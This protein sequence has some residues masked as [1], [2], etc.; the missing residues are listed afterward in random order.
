MNSDRWNLSV[1]VLLCVFLGACKSDRPKSQTNVVTQHTK[2]LN[3][4]ENWSIDVL[5]F[6]TYTVPVL[7]P[8]RGER[9]KKAAREIKSLNADLIGLQEVFY[10]GSR[11]ILSKLTGMKY[12]EYFSEPRTF[13]SG[14][15]ILSNSEMTKKTFWYHLLMG[16]MGRAEFYSG[17]GIA[18]T[19]IIHKELPVSFF[20]IHLLSRKGKDADL[21]MDRDSLDRM[22]ELFEI[23]TQIVEQTDSDAFI[24]A[25][26]FNMN[27]Y[28]REFNFF[29]NLTSL[30]GVTLQETDKKACTYCPE[31]TFN[32]KSEGQLDYIW[33]SPRLKVKEHAVVLNEKHRIDGI[34]MNL[35]DH[36]GI[37]AKIGINQDLPLVKKE[38][39]MNKSLQSISSL[40]IMLENELASKNVDKGLEER[41]CRSCR[42]KDVLHIVKKYEKA[43]SKDQ[44]ELN[45]NERSLSLRLKSYYNNFR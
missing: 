43:L 31:N 20:N 15:F 39:A 11:E 3:Y 34:R 18:K 13:G 9:L 6:N 44:N 40:R 12:S 30:N 17:K 23:F 7:P 14:N 29:K 2:N 28:N 33:I 36:Y 37:K 26:D 5:T 41:F 25:G 4:P 10:D 32:K 45:D 35:S 8:V 1:I 21:Y 19:T 42:L 27:I 38:E 16:K 24:L 22:S